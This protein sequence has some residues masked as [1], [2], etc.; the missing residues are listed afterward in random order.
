MR[1]FTA[2]PLLFWV[3]T[4]AVAHLAHVWA[5]VPAAVTPVAQAPEAGSGAR[6]DQAVSPGAGQL[7]AHHEPVFTRQLPAGLAWNV[8]PP[9]IAPEFPGS[10]LH[11]LILSAARLSANPPPQRA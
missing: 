8:Q 1:L 3:G 11:D 5:L 6:A 2:I 10:R 9:T 4:A 7:F